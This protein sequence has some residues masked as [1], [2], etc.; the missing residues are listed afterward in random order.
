VSRPYVVALTGGIGSGKSAVADLFAQHGVSVI[1]TDAIA[2]QL[3]APAGPAMAEIIEAFGASCAR[4]DGSLDRAWMR[5]LVFKDASARRRLE[6]ILHP[7]IHAEAAR[8]LD[9]ALG[10]YALLVVPLLLETG[11]YDDLID[12]I[13]VVDCSEEMQVKRVMQRNGYSQSVIH[14]IM[15]SQASR[16][17]RL[18]IADDIIEND[19]DLGGLAEQVARLHECYVGRAATHQI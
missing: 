1:D 16:A 6:A 7:R 10:D 3:T 12:R 18:G 4:P 9:T 14:A 13:L 11:A 8:G 15:S 17:R 19:A 5:A 2:H